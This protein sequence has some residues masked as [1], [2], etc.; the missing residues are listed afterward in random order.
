M[1]RC[2]HVDAGRKYF[3]PSFFARMIPRIAE[4]GFTALQLHFSENEGFR[5][6]SLNHPEILSSHYLSRAEL[7]DIIALA[8]RHGLNL[9]PAI[10]MPGHLAQVLRAHSHLRLADTEE[11]R[12]A[13]DYSLGEARDFMVDLI[14][15]FAPLFP[16]SSWHLGADEFIDFTRA[17][18][19]YP[20][21]IDYAEAVAGTRNAA[22]GFAFFINGL[23]EHL[24][25]L[26]KTDVRVWND[27]FYRSDSPQTVDLHPKATVC[28]WTGWD[29][30]MAPV[31]EF[32]ARGHR[33]I[34]ASDRLYYVLP[35]GESAYA[36]HPDPHRIREIFHPGLFSDHAGRTQNFPSPYPD[37][38]TG[39]YVCI[40]CDDP[41][42]ETP[43]EIARGIDP[44]LQA[45]AEATR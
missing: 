34:N 21:L 13:L 39:C 8:E 27:G 20:Q 42:G 40:W 33:M 45:F 6:E 19:N 26:G 37:W 18:E 30:A 10:D 2:L 17:K 44:L 7:D 35:R 16:G 5:L 23:I 3:P 1:E 12:R 36:V 38:L 29:K 11:G 41:H 32:L 22:D 28:Y 9:I 25:G 31:E 43:E 24:A 15:E 14:D 4:L